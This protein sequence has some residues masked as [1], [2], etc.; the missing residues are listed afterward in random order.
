MKIVIEMYDDTGNYI[1]G[2]ALETACNSLIVNNTCVIQ[3]G[4]IHTNIAGLTS[5]D[6]ETSRIEH[7]IEHDALDDETPITAD[8]YTMQ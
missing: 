5:N 8:E 1:I 3:H 6:V 4:Q 2:K 7:L